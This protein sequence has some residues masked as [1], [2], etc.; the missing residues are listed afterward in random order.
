ML[1][2]GALPQQ[3]Y[4]YSFSGGSHSRTLP[5]IRARAVGG[6]S[7]LTAR[8]LEAAA[9]RPSHSHLGHLLISI[10]SFT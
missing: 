7:R 5:S 1:K 9:G 6:V 10:M 3:G 4:G 8:V 2:G